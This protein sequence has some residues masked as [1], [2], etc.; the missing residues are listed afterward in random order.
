[1]FFT[2]KR[3]RLPPWVCEWCGNQEDPGWI[4]QDKVRQEWCNWCAGSYREKTLKE[5]VRQ[6]EL[7]ALV[8]GSLAAAAVGYRGPSYDANDLAKEAMNIAKNIM[9]QGKE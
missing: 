8:A 2:K 5:R 1:M 4:E 3:L 9:N 6:E 7:A